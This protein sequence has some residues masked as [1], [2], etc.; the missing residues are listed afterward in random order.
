MTAEY[1][2]TAAAVGIR[3]R[4]AREKAGYSQ[5]R[6][7]LRIGTS[8]RN[9]LRWENGHNLPRAEHIERIAEATGKTTDYFLGEDEEEEAALSADLARVLHN[10]V[11]A[12]VREALAERERV[13]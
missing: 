13:S 8:R 3:I 10:L 1:R 5:E 12:A 4:K 7:A 6:L 9:M 11:G 2:A